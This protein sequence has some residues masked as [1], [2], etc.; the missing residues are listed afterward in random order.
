MM[1]PFAAL[2]LAIA[3]ASP[4][5]AQTLTFAATGD[6][7][8]KTT[9]KSVATLIKNKNVQAVTIA[10]DLCYGASPILAQVIDPKYGYLKTT[11]PATTNLLA[12]PGNHDYS[13]ACGS[14]LKNYLSYFQFSNN[15]RY[16]DAIRG[17]VHFIFVNSNS[18]EPDGTA[19]SSKQG[20]WVKGKLAASTSPWKVVVFHHAPFS[21]GS[22]Q[23]TVKMRWPF[24]AWGADAVISG[25]DHDYE[26]VMRDDNKDGARMPYFVSGLGGESKRGFNSIVAGSAVRYSSQFGAL[27]ATATSTSLSFE[28]RTINGNIIDSLHMTKGGTTTSAFEFRTL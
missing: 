14:S 16:H 28:F 25:H 1:R 15:E 7:G 20:N 23:S 10:G 3:L 9:S 6:V 22:H 8:N 26:R 24:E 12:S 27:F 19:A 4:L 5:S 21:S 13:D 2:A 17:P 11:N 18:Q